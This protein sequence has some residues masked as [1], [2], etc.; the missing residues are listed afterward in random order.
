MNN[1]FGVDVVRSRPSPVLKRSDRAEDRSQISPPQNECSRRRVRSPTPAT[2]RSSMG[3]FHWQH[4]GLR[5][6]FG[7]PPGLPCLEAVMSALWQGS[8]GRP[9]LFGNLSSKHPFPP[10]PSAKAGAHSVRFLPLAS[11]N[12]PAPLSDLGLQKQFYRMGGMPWSEGGGSVRRV[13][14]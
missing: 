6:G 3:V 10:S 9:L 14:E 8:Q 7:V 4:L 11:P 13:E 5:F 1:C 2:H 12:I